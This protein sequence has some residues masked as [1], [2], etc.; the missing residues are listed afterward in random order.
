MASFTQVDTFANR[1]RFAMDTRK[2]KQIDI[3]RNT[4]ID[5][6]AISRYLS[7][8]YEPKSKPIYILAKELDVS[9]QWLMG[10]DAPMERPQE[11]KNNDAISDIVVSL[12]KDGSLIP[13][14]RKVIALP[15]EKRK[16]LESL[17]E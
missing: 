1:L 6:G 8:E 9:E 11:Q 5:R 3:V 16:S 7:G 12:R 17:L 4:G 15:T 13:L 14:V 2:K 10:Y